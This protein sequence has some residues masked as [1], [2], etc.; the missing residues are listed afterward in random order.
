MS[1]I[2]PV[3]KSDSNWSM[4]DPWS[5]EVKLSMVR[6]HYSKVLK[7]TGLVSDIMFPPVRMQK[8]KD[9]EKAEKKEATTTTKKSKPKSKE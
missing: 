5:Q 7:N 9:K 3:L 2:P 6:Q 4:K 1:N 8:P